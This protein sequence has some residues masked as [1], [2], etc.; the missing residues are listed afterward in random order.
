MNFFNC[1]SKIQE[2]YDLDLIKQSELFEDIVNV[3]LRNDHTQLNQYSKIWSEEEWRKENND[4][5]NDRDPNKLNMGPID[6]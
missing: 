6:K 5:Q 3:F 1:F 2:K 4:N